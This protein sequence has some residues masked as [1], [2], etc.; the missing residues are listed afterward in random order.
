[1]AKEAKH[2]TS[3]KSLI[4][5]ENTPFPADNG[6]SVS[7]PPLQ[8]PQRP[9]VRQPDH[10]LEVDCV[11]SHIQQITQNNVARR[12]IKR[13]ERAELKA[14]RAERRLQNV[15]I[16][17]VCLL[18]PSLTCSHLADPP[19]LD[20]VHRQRACGARLIGS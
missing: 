3:V 20:M 8:R 4:L 17:Q 16:T 7:A 18:V 13:T 10:V 15:E 5:L 1:M 19:W 12:Q 14:E 11:K 9:L 2:G 6:A